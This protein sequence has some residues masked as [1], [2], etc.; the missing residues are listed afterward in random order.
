MKKFDSVRDEL[1]YIQKKNKGLISPQVVVSFAEN[2]NTH[3]HSKFEWDDEKAGHEYR[4]WQARKVITLEF[5]VIQKEDY[6]PVGPTR[7]FV[8]LRDD[9][10]K[11]GGYRLITD[12]MEDE[13]MRHNLLE[14]AFAE[15]IRIKM[16]YKRLTEL[17]K[18]FEAI[19]ALVFEEV[20]N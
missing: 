19:D 5:E 2:E 15:L 11:E 4:L 17:N 7:L 8:S 16:K 18:V 20:S 14:E 10:S 9:R 1:L 3:L 6:R 12:V 13:G